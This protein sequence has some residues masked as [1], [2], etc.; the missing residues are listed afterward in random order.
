MPL[1]IF[2]VTMVTILIFWTSLPEEIPMHYDH[3]RGFN[4]EMKKEMLF[5]ILIP[6]YFFFLL[7][8]LYVRRNDDNYAQYRKFLYFLRIVVI[9]IVSMTTLLFVYHGL[10]SKP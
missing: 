6:G 2:G 9:A 3:S 8:E 5:L 4:N 7:V 1:S 10:H